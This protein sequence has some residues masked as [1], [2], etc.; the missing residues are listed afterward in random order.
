M[1][2]LNKGTLTMT[3]KSK[4]VFVA[5]AALALSS[6]VDGKGS[7]KYRQAYDECIE[8]MKNSPYSNT[9]RNELCK[10]YAERIY[11]GWKK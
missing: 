4:Y 3:S 11:Y 5:L 9:M 1:I 6:C 10:E 7:E 8:D 2:L